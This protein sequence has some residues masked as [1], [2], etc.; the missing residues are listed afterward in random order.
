MKSHYDIELSTLQYTKLSEPVE[1]LAIDL[2]SYAAEHSTAE[3]LMNVVGFT[4]CRT[5]AVTALIYW[6]ELALTN[7][8]VLNT[9]DEHCHWAQAAILFFDELTVSEGHRYILTTT[10]DNGYLGAAVSAECE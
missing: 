5:S 8:I 1:L 3:Q 10:C 7:D 2:N 6:F 4:A 9:N